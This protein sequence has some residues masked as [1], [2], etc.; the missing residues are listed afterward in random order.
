[1]SFHGTVNRPVSDTLSHF[2]ADHASK[3]KFFLEINEAAYSSQGIALPMIDDC[4]HQYSI[5]LG[6]D[7]QQ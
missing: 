4:V 3:F 1:M 7:I 5:A 2:V 6:L